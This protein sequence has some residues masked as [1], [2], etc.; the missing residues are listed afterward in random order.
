MKNDIFRWFVL[1]GT[2]DARELSFFVNKVIPF[3]KNIEMIDH[4]K[5]DIIFV[6]EEK[7]S[8]R[9]IES[10]LIKIRNK[11][12]KKSFLYRTNYF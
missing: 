11:T 3:L 6:A 12:Q 7:R 2:R 9:F 10:R 5:M 1:Y 4:V 8:A